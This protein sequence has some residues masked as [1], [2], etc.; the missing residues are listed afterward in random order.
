VAPPGGGRS[1]GGK[2]PR[3]GS[4]LGSSGHAGSSGS[5]PATSNA[6][7]RTTAIHHEPATVAAAPK[8]NAAAAHRALTGC[9]SFDPATPVLMA[10][11]TTKPIK[12]IKVGDMVLATDPATGK[13]TAQPVTH[14]GWL[15][16]TEKI[17]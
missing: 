7:A 15:V 9:H 12:D 5:T 8:N 11:H 1:T 2:T 13:T 4:D 17:R 16:V 3:N 14:S 10:D 6:P